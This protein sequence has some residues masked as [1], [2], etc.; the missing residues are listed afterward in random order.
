MLIFSFIILF[1]VTTKTGLHAVVIKK[2]IHCIPP[3]SKGTLTLGN[4]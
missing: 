1:W 2:H 3:P 4:L